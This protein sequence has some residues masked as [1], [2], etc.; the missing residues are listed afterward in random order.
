MKKKHIILIHIIYW[1]YI[2]F[3]SL[4]ITIQGRG[5]EELYVKEYVL[6]MII[7][8]IFFYL[9]YFTL[10]YFFRLKRKIISILICIGIIALITLAKEGI[11]LALFKYKILDHIS[12]EPVAMSIK[13]YL[14]QLRGSFVN[15]IYAVFIFVLID[16]IKNIK[17]KAELISQ[18]QTSELALLR[19][20]ISPHF[21][22]N[23][24][25]NID[26]L[27]ARD[28]DRASESV[29][30]LSEI[31]RYMIYE[32]GSEKV[33]LAKEVKYL[34]S[35]ISLQKLRLK[36]PNYI[37]FTVN[38]TVSNKMI[39]PMIFISFVENAF[40][41]G[42]KQMISPGIIITLNVQEKSIFFTST[43]YFNQDE[44]AIKDK[45]SCIGLANVKRRL[46][47]IYPNKHDLK[48]L[49]DNNIYTVQLTIND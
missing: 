18:K 31:M 17:Q 2:T 48:I 3:Q 13:S 16:W 14:F 44:L 8:F 42:L 28:P 46:E 6:W 36:D 4:V 47:L 25:N 32:T 37:S 22:F 12:G 20:Q 15:S 43:N 23:T 11:F 7:N 9:F 40:K 38:N 21:L 26:S 35:Y 34:E 39:A 45:T 5:G 30:K 10:P 29:I 27:I 24:L 19:S 41:H 33:S 1:F 49:S